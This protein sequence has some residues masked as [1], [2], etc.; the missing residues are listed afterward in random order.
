MRPDRVAKRQETA[1]PHS[2]C[3]SVGVSGGNRAEQWR[4]AFIHHSWR[5]HK[6]C[7]GGHALAGGIKFIL[8][9]LSI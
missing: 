5:K 6:E 7:S 2:A 3:I 9:A 4:Q 1:L 8:G